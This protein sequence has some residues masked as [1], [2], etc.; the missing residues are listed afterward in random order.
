M[1]LDDDEQLQPCQRSC[2]RAMPLARCHTPERLEA[3]LVEARFTIGDAEAAAAGLDSA[4]ERRD[5][6]W[7]VE[8]LVGDQ[9]WPRA[10]LW[11][12]PPDRLNVEAS[13]REAYEAV[14][15]VVK[16]LPTMVRTRSKREHEDARHQYYGYRQLRLHRDDEHR[17]APGPAEAIDALHVERERRW[18]QRPHVLLGDVSPEEAAKDDNRIFDL[19]DLLELAQVRGLERAG[20][21]PGADL[22]RVRE[23]L[24]IGRRW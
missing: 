19:Y 23:A 9:V 17:P 13:S 15:G 14:A 21:P 16:A 8:V 3:C 11:W 5:G 2:D 7:R 20:L 4:F 6:G 1:Y 24:G 12:S 18:L 10:L 22:N